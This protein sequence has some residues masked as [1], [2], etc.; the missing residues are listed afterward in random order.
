MS[1]YVSVYKI[2]LLLSTV[3]PALRYTRQEVY[4]FSNYNYFL[5]ILYFT[6]PKIIRLF[7]FISLAYTIDRFIF[8]SLKL[9]ISNNIDQIYY[10]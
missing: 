9:V 1:S 4:V 7:L 2:Y 8:I 6:I 10:N 3:P 5:Y